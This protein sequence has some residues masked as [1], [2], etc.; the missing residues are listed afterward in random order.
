MDFIFK[1]ARA[2]LRELT[3]KHEPRSP[4]Q[5]IPVLMSAIVPALC[6]T[7]AYYCCFSWLRFYHPRL[8]FV[9]GLP[10][11]AVAAVVS[12]QAKQLLRNAVPA[13][14]SM[15]TAVGCW[16][17][18]VLALWLGEQNYS[19]HIFSF[20]SYQDLADYINID[21]SEDKG[22]SFMDSGQVYFKEASY[23]AVDEFVAFKSEATFCVAPILSE[24][25]LQPSAPASKALGQNFPNVV[26]FWAVGLNC[27]NQ[28]TGEY[29]CGAVGDKTA[30]SGLRLLRDDVRPFYALAVQ[31]WEAKKCPEDTNT[32]K[33]YA[34]ASPL[35][36]PRSGHPLFFHW[37][38]DPLLEVDLFYEKA[39]SM[40]SMHIVCFTLGNFLIGLLLSWALFLMGFK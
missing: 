36:C 35:I 4:W 27:C 33:G 20:Y 31:E 28:E 30:R 5:P 26:D 11:L 37:V 3:R 34:K 40:F 12:L 2:E 1:E 32:A 7:W 39:M 21:P 22:Q 6:F 13:R 14:G 25:A 38:A 9:L 17:A 24:D 10:S 18:V 16:A 23:V 19:W 29:H 8:A 15:V